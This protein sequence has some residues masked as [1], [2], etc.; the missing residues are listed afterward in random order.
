MRLPARM[1]SSPQ[2]A[3]LVCPD[4]GGVLSTHA[5]GDAGYLRFV[6]QVGHAYSVSTLLSA[7]EE[8][9]E[10]ALWSGV[11]LLEELADL[12]TD[13]VDRGGPDGSRPDRPAADR[14]IERLHAQAKQ[15][16]QLLDGNEPIDLGDAAA[17]DEA[18]P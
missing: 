11:Y 15:L 5:E 16:R 13:L 6:C 12:L 14:R 2:P 4:C 10:E 18:R 17:S 1:G 3:S 9:L 8:R 7:K